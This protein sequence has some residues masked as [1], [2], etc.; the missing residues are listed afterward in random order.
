M[1]YP[2]SLSHARLASFSEVCHQDTLNKTSRIFVN[3]QLRRYLRTG[4]REG[5]FFEM[6][7]NGN[8]QKIGINENLLRGAA[9][10][11]TPRHL[12]P[13][14]NGKKGG[15]G[16]T[17]S[18]LGEKR[19]SLGKRSGAVSVEIKETMEAQNRILPIAS[20][21]GSFPPEST[22]LNLSNRFQ[23]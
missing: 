12:F 10:G 8:K 23:N 18:N 3:S 20:R 16:R 13:F 5:Q 6:R 11:S 7:K 17:Q 14:K 15:S 9:W 1:G 2:V 4:V 19:R 21:R 22:K